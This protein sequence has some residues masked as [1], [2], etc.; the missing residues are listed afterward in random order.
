MNINDI[1]KISLTR[2]ACAFLA[3][4]NNKTCL[5]PCF[6]AATPG[7]NC[8]LCLNTSYAPAV[9]H[10]WGD[11]VE[12]IP[13]QNIPRS[14]MHSSLCILHFCI[15][16]GSGYMRATP[17]CLHCYTLQLDHSRARSV[18]RH[19]WRVVLLPPVQWRFPR[20]ASLWEHRQLEQGEEEGNSDVLTGSE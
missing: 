6:K 2:F 5:R 10:I 20:R 12:N 13:Q 15:L 4:P 1:C 11:W 14:S 18:A 8:L 9:F 16:C 7:G 3:P 19:G 17:T